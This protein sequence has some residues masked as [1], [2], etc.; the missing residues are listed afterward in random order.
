[1][2]SVHSR[3]PLAI[4]AL[5]PIGKEAQLAADRQPR[6]TV[7]AVTANEGAGSGPGSR[8]CRFTYGGFAGH[9]L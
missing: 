3:A 6:E 2:A 7:E 5:A 4:P 9:A 1:M 8:A